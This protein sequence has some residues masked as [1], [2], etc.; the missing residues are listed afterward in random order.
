MTFKYGLKQL[1]LF[2]VVLIILVFQACKK[3]LDGAGEDLVLNDLLGAF[4]NDTTPLTARTVKGDTINT[5]S[6]IYGNIMVGNYQDHVFGTVATSGYIQL[7]LS[8]VNPRFPENF[9]VDSVVLSLAYFGRSYGQNDP[10]YYQV[11]ELDA[12]FDSSKTYFSSS[13][14]AVKPGNLIKPGYET[15]DPRPELVTNTTGAV[16]PSLRIRLKESVGTTLLSLDTTVLDK[17][18]HFKEYFKG[19][20][21]SSAT[22]DGQVVNYDISNSA[23]KLIVYYHDNEDPEA[24]TT[25]YNFIFSSRCRAFTEIDQQYNGTSIS[26]I[27]SPDGIDGNELCYAQSGGGSNVIVDLSQTA[28]L[29]NYPNITINRAELVVPYNAAEKPAPINLLLARYKDSDGK[30]KLLKDDGMT[31]T[32]GGS[33]RT[34]SGLYSFNITGH[35]QSYLRGDLTSPEIYLIPNAG[36]LSV[37]R[38]ILHGPGF[39]P[40]VKTENMRLIITYSFKD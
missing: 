33:V 35:L 23:T 29:K 19:L 27:F 17:F 36:I 2:S 15:V 1:G 4:Q 31:Q 8:T 7:D 11:H 12:I 3:P 22:I 39:N 38:S 13:S 21:I 34:T 10:L 14:I 32:V 25:D 40:D 9:T 18:N 24:E 5:T 16:A 20:R 37:T 30:F 6:T 26:G 28:W